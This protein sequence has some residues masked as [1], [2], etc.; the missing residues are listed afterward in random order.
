MDMATEYTQSP[1]MQHGRYCCPGTGA[2]S[3]AN[4]TRF[5]AAGW[6][7]EF[8]DGSALWASRE[9]FDVRHAGN[10]YTHGH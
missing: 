7:A 1:F 4:M 9:G 2:G 3:P 8:R 10:T 5:N 6:Y